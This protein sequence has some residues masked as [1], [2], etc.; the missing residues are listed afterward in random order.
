MESVAL[1][2]LAMLSVA[3]S[4]VLAVPKMRPNPRKARCRASP[5]VVSAL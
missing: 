3:V 5:E 2:T 4:T 1:L